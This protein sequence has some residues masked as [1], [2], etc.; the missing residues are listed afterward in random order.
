MRTEK[1]RERERE[2]EKSRTD[3]ISPE[4][5]GT[6]VVAA[7]IESGPLLSKQQKQGAGVLALA[8]SRMH[9][10]SCLSCPV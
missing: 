5:V 9:A 4:A 10:A 7:T 8:V 1:E 3:I 6:A 2:R